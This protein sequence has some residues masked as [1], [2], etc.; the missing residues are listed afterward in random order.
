M[1]FGCLSDAIQASSGR[2][3]CSERPSG[4]LC[5]NNPAVERMF[6]FGHRMACPG[7]RVRVF[8]GFQSVFSFMCP[9][10]EDTAG[11][12][13]P[14]IRWHHGPLPGTRGRCRAAGDAQAGSGAP[15]VDCPLAT[16]TASR[17]SAEQACR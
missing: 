3:T 16:S 8:Y 2:Y 6:V 5:H 13:R 12:G 1:L 10:G 14:Q 9:V 7:S 17:W 15:C 11:T 4:S